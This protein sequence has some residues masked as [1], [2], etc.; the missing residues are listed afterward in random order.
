MEDSTK[1]P[2]KLPPAI[3]PATHP[4]GQE[5]LDYTSIRVPEQR[6]HSGVIVRHYFTEDT[7]QRLKNK[8]PDRWLT[9]VVKLTD[10]NN[11]Y[12]QPFEVVCEMSSSMANDSNLRKLL[13]N[14]RPAFGKNVLSRLAGMEV[15]AA[16]TIV[17]GDNDSYPFPKIFPTEMWRRG[18]GK[19]PLGLKDRDLRGRRGKRERQV[20]TVIPDAST[21]PLPTT[22]LDEVSGSIVMESTYNRRRVFPSRV[23]KTW[24]KP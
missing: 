23:L 20:A 19:E 17:K 2:Q 18:E 22:P 16:V 12:D 14:L 24:R 9:I 13:A 15:D 4:A 5:D 11:D 6:M 3:A 21:I 7:K 10:E 1:L 8:Q